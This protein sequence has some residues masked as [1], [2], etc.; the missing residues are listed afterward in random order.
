MRH[1]WSK[2]R[3][4]RSR[5]QWSQQRLAVRRRNRGGL[6]LQPSHQLWQVPPAAPCRIR[7]TLSL[8]HNLTPPPRRRP[9]FRRGPMCHKGKMIKVLEGANEKG[10]QPPEDR[11][12]LA[13]EV[14]EDIA[15]SSEGV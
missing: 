1:S 13:A 4:A 12:A 8:P 5:I 6:F 10:K 14:L 7:P 11:Q 15:S 9:F 3:I 2:P